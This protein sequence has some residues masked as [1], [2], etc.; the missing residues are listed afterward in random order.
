[1]RLLSKQWTQ[2]QISNNSDEVLCWV[3]LPDDAKVNNLWL[4]SHIQTDREY[5]NRAYVYGMS[6]WIARKAD[7]NEQQDYDEEW[8]NAIEK[9]Y[10]GVASSTAMF[11]VMGSDL[12]EDTTP[13][14]EPGHLN[15]EGIFGA[16]QNEIRGNKEFFARKKLLTLSNAGR[17]FNSGDNTVKYTDLVRTTIRFGFGGRVEGVHTGMVGFSNPDLT[18]TTASVPNTPL[19][20]EWTLLS[21]IDEFLDEMMAYAL[22]LAPGGSIADPYQN[23]SYFIAKLLEGDPVEDSDGAWGQTNYRVFTKATWDITL[24]GRARTHVLTSG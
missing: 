13:Q 24:P 18:N 19:D 3:P 10:E 5:E 6:G 12:S 11:G 9:D 2:R 17:N 8:D 15:V 20:D 4:E 14:D 23:I 16:D 22:G 1:M 7:A 21:F